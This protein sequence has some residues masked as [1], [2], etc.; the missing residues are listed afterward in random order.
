MLF[1]QIVLGNCYDLKLPKCWLQLYCVIYYNFR[2]TFVPYWQHAKEQKCISGVS[3]GGFAEL[4][5]SFVQATPTSASGVY[6][7]CKKISVKA[8]VDSNFAPSSA[9]R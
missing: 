4:D 6:P 7:V 5:R 1:F 3:V 8:I 9:A 2:H